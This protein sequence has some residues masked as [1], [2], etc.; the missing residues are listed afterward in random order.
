[1]EK[2]SKRK[3]LTMHKIIVYLEMKI[4]KYKV[5]IGKKA[6]KKLTLLVKEGKKKFISKY[7]ENFRKVLVEK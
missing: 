4:R 1:M 3:N 2:L 5:F 6:I 7:V